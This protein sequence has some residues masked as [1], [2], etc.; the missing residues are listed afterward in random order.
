MA[1]IKLVWLKRF[2]GLEP[3]RLNKSY[4][5]YRAHILKTLQIIIQEKKEDIQREVQ[6]WCQIG[7]RQHKRCKEDAKFMMQSY[8]FNQI[9]YRNIKILSSA[10]NQPTSLAELISCAF[11]FLQVAILYE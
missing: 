2:T 3:S 7:W 10:M 5:I 4:I 11:R 6:M 9:W 8:Q 1:A